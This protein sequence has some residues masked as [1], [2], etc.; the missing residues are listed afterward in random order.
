[1]AAHARPA[2]ALRRA[3]VALTGA[4]STR[5]SIS[6]ASAS[7]RSPSTA[8]PMATAS[9]SSSTAR[10]CS[11]AASAG[12]RWISP[13]SRRTRAAYRAALEQLRDAGMN[14]VR[15]GGTMAYETDA[16]HDLCDELG[17]PGVAGLHVRQH[18]LS[19]GGR[20]VRAQR[21]RRGDA[22]RS[23]RSSRGRR[24][25]SC[26][27]A[28]RSISRRRCSA[29]S[30]SQWSARAGDELLARS[31]AGSSRQARCGC[32]RRRPAA[33]FPFQVDSGV[34]HYYG[35]G[36][37][38]RPFEDARRAGVRFAAECLAFSNVPDAAT[39]ANAPGATVESA[40]TSPALEGARPARR[41][42]GLGLRGRPRSLCRAPVRRPRIRALRARDPERYLALGRVATGEAMLRT[43]AEWR[44]PGSTCRGGLVWFARDLQP[45]AGWGII[46]STG[47]PKAAVLVPQARARAG[48]PPE[49]GRRP[50]RTVASRG[51]RHAGP[52]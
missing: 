21:R 40:G 34:S 30:P 15:I 4:T 12:R 25:P 29:C 36:A 52:R 2:A 22:D 1:M 32:R 24:S 23:R 14:M 31:R 7:A 18:G 11:A 5:P 3:R 38:R 47:Q 6:A 9:A 51:E 26:A 48:R 27:A 42:R 37:Y 33:R 28:A 43:F 16:F 35:V 8:A 44:R 10:R 17:H 49:R 41:R 13:A 19:V 39:V 20:G 46:D 50:E 45:G